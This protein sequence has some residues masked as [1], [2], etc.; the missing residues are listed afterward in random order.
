M[1]V[2]VF[3]TGLLDRAELASCVQEGTHGD[4][5]DPVRMCVCVLCVCA[6]VCARARTRTCVLSACVLSACVCWWLCVCVCVCIWEGWGEAQCVCVCG[7]G[8]RVSVCGVL[9]REGAVRAFTHMR[10]RA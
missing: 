1:Y 5:V 9:C 8:L 7:G 10:A 4:R 3:H 6:R 2:C